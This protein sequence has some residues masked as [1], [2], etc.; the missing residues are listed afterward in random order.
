LRMQDRVRDV[1]RLSPIPLLTRFLTPSK[2]REL[3]ARAA[4][5]FSVV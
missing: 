3:L 4:L 2:F 5:I 1:D